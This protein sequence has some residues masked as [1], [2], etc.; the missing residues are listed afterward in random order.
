MAEP[1]QIHVVQFWRRRYDK[2]VIEWEI[3]KEHVEVLQLN[4][5]AIQ[6]ASPYPPP[7]TLGAAY[8]LAQKCFRTFAD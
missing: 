2:V 4:E 5:S 8:E 1:N 7:L 6:V 3:G